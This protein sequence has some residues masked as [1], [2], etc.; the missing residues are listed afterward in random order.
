MIRR[1]PIAR[2]APPRKKRATPRPGRLKGA[3]LA[4]LR[5]ECFIRDNFHCRECGIA[6]NPFLSMFADQAAHM[7]HIKAKRI[8]LDTLE[9]VRTL[10]GACHRKEHAYGKSMQKPCPKKEVA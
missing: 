1:T 10:C 7:A 3:A 2:T 8:G 5:A 4:R 9:N 6:V